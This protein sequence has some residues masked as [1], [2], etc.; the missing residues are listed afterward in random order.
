MQG[1]QMGLDVF[2][3]L[4]I[5]KW[6]INWNVCSRNKFNY[7]SILSMHYFWK[8]TCSK[9]PPLWFKLCCNSFLKLCTTCCNKMPSVHTSD[10]ILFF[11]SVSTRALS[12]EGTQIF[13]SFFSSLSNTYHCPLLYMTNAI[14]YTCICV[15]LTSLLCDQSGNCVQT[16]V[17]VLYVSQNMQETLLFWNIPLDSPHSKKWGGSVTLLSEFLEFYLLVCT[18]YSW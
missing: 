9:C 18:A 16:E 14:I 10:I 17:C 2:Q 15:Y 1:P 13:F 12:F 4:T 11:S 8:I 7:Y 6:L 5:G 3:H